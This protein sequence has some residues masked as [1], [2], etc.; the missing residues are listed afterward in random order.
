MKTLTFSWFPMS[1][2]L[3]HSKQFSSKT[4]K[5]HTAAK[6]CVLT[7]LKRGASAG[8]E[9]KGDKVTEAV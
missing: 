7:G 4:L 2:F 1:S 6:A 8:W 5:W 9:I 3:Y